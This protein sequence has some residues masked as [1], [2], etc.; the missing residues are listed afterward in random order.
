MFD[1]NLDEVLV[2]LIVGVYD[3]DSVGDAGGEAL[4]HIGRVAEHPISKGASSES[5]G[6]RLSQGTQ[7]TAE[8]PPLLWQTTHK[9]HT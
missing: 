3:G 9:H 5:Q 4:T 8:V 6:P 1:T 2:G 7:S